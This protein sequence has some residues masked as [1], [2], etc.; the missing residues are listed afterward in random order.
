MVHGNGRGQKAGEEGETGGAG[1]LGLVKHT[2]RRPMIM[3]FVCVAHFIF[4]ANDKPSG[5]KQMTNTSAMLI[6]TIS[7]SALPIYLFF[8]F[9]FLVVCFMFFFLLLLF[10]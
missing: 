10:F 2:Q 1:G 7:A 5:A 6:E 9:L 8:A 3:S 4:R